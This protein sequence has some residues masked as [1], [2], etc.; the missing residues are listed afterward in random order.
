VVQKINKKTREVTLRRQDGSVMSVVVGPEVRNFDQIKVGDIVEAKTIELLAVAIE[1]ATTQV[2]ERRETTGRGDTRSALGEKPAATTQR[3]VEIV[4]TVQEIDRKARIVTVKGAVRRWSS[5]WARASTCRRSRS[6]TTSTPSTSN[7]TP[8]AS[9]RRAV[10][11]E[12]RAASRSRRFLRP[13]RGGVS[14]ANVLYPGESRQNKRQGGRRAARC[15]PSI[16]CRRRCGNARHLG[17]RGLGVTGPIGGL[18]VRLPEGVE[19]ALERRQV[20]IVGRRGQRL[21]HALVAGGSP[22][23]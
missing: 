10:G 3:T 4:A 5:R 22:S 18:V 6:A 8:S 14:G 23:G 17:G 13:R 1:P 20:A 15:I 9:D 21:L 12:T 16:R 19:Q 2:R 7:P 11:A